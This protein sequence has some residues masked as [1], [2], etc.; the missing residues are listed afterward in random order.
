MASRI[1]SITVEINNHS[2]SINGTDFTAFRKLF[3]MTQSRKGTFNF[4][5][6]WHNFKGCKS[7]VLKYP[8]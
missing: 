4:S 2:F 6:F 3:G 8:L 5:P 7:V 1:K